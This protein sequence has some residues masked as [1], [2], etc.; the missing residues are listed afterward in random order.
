MS[1]A[2]VND[3]ATALAHARHYRF[4]KFPAGPR[5]AAGYVS[6]WVGAGYPGAGAAP[7]LY[8]AGS[9]YTCDKSTVG[10][11]PYVN[12]T[13]KN[14]LA[15][16]TC[17]NIGNQAG[18]LYLYDRLWSCSG[19][20]F[21]AGTY[22]V[23]TPG[24]LPARITDG[25]LDCEL[26]LENFV[27]T[28]VASGG[29]VASYLDSAGSAKSGIITAVTSGNN[30]GQLQQV[31]INDNLG[32]SQLTSITTDTSWTSGTFG[33]TIMRRIADITIP[34]MTE[35]TILDWTALGLP[36]IGNDVCLQL[37]YQCQSTS[38]PQLYGD[39]AV[40]DQ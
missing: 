15:R 39:L 37:V 34:P 28:G 26:W 13:T 32:I 11:F 9:G 31:V 1:I 35:V 7:P 29:V 12:A 2:T 36:Q 6:T 23:T 18:V 25:G 19:M 38:N 5:N 16:A 30:I 22:T 21:A 33:A 3:I 17:R 40:I 20:G 10:A 4:M 27:A 8:T 24:S 14:Y